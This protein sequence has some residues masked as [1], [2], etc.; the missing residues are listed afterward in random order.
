MKTRNLSPFWVLVI[1][2]SFIPPV[3][4]QDDLCPVVV[5]NAL[6]MVSTACSATERNQVCYGNIFLEAEPQSGV[7]NLAFEKL[8]DIAD[9]AQ[10]ASLRLST[11]N[12]ETLEWGV[13]L[14][15]VQANLPATVPGQ[16]VLFLL[17][18]DVKVENSGVEQSSILVTATGKLNVRGGPS[19]NHSVIGQV[20]EGQIVNAI[21]RNQASDWLHVE[22]SEDRVG[23]I[24]APLVTADGDIRD[25]DVLEGV[26]NSVDSTEFGPMQAFY[27]QSG[28][29]DAPCA[30]APDS[31]I[32]IQTPQGAG[33]IELWVNEVNIRLGSTVFLQAVPGAE[34]FV[35]VLEGWAFVEASDA[36]IALP[37]GTRARIPLDTNSAASGPPIGPE[38]L[39]ALGFLPLE[40]LDIPITVAESPLPSEEITEAVAPWVNRIVPGFYARYE[41]K[42]RMTNGMRR[43]SYNYMC[44]HHDGVLGPR[45]AD[46]Y[47]LVSIEPDGTVI[48]WT[49]RYGGRGIT[50]IRFQAEDLLMENG[51]PDI[52]IPLDNRVYT[53]PS[54]RVMPSNVT[55]TPVFSPAGTEVI[56]I[57]N[58]SVLAQVY[59]GEWTDDTG[60]WVQRSR[61]I[62][63][64]DSQ[65]GLLLRVEE[66]RT[67]LSCSVC[68]FS[69]S[70]RTPF[71]S[72][73][74][75]WELT[76]TNQPLA[77][78]DS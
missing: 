18:G 54:F 59:S 56:T 8:G 45:I 68:D 41:C 19:T 24:Y 55:V 35:N 48:M 52:W 69:V 16:N 28:V 15:R 76:E 72:F 6:N 27:F 25:L 64:F 10:L 26:E 49:S 32:L 66:T 78:T 22:L 60:G 9:I 40:N 37:A 33:Q 17:F 5:Q 12:V 61:S 74:G 57:M 50:N 44:T 53:F 38:P 47:R 21:A 73:R 7:I 36:V 51:I 11:M 1:V 62:Q 23:W 34:M 63:H 67:I 14:M 58:R 42:E 46:E 71:N 77:E 70:P 39:D 43:D 75:L 65:S 4:A 2:L 29:G 20:T 30:E 13:A 3:L 31:G